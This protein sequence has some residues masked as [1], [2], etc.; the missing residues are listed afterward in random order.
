[1]MI[2]IEKI[3]ALMKAELAATC[4]L[5][6]VARSLLASG[7]KRLRARL[8]LFLAEVLGIHSD[9]AIPWALANEILHNASLVHDDIQDRDRFR[10][11]R[12]TVWAEHGLELA[13]SLGD[14]LLMKPFLLVQKIPVAAE[15]RLD[16]QGY[17]AQTV[18]RMAKAQVDEYRL[19]VTSPNLKSDYLQVISDKTSALFELPV[20]GLC[21]LAGLSATESRQWVKAFQKLG[22][23][24]QIL[25]DLK[26][27][28]GLKGKPNRG[29]DLCEGKISAIVVAYVAMRPEKAEELQS[30]LKSR[31]V[32]VEEVDHW[33]REFD[34]SGAIRFVESWL[35]ELWIE[36]ESLLPQKLQESKIREMVCVP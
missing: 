2:E 19:T 6:D 4:P 7:G 9:Q 21:R 17:I 26:D 3:D 22:E 31:C 14:H 35:K 36:F 18:S 34:D 32:S 24:F 15:A 29:A 16:L 27:I 12:P 28:R 30:I 25:D 8:T 20:I 10:R 23:Y 1:M 13:I 11:G 33:L 5:D